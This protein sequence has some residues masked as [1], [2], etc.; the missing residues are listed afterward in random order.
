[1]VP[2]GRFSRNAKVQFYRITTSQYLAGP[3]STVIFR[4]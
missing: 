4:S 1:M 2:T 3:L